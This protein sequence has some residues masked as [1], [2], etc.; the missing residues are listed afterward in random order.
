MIFI[1]CTFQNSWRKCSKRQTPQH[2]TRLWGT[3]YFFYC[4]TRKPPGF[5]NQI[6]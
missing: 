3:I 6:R 4:S 5:F 2:V 1:S